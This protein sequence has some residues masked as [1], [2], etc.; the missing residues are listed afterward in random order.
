MDTLLL[1]VNS[2]DLSVVDGSIAVVAGPYALAQ[3]VA[4]ACRLYLGELWYDTTQGMPY[5]QRILGQRPPL[6]FIQAQLVAAA[7]GVPG[8]TQA[9]AVV[10]LN[11]TNRQITG[12]IDLT[13]AQG[14]V[15]VGGVIGGA[16]WYI[17]GATGGAFAS[18]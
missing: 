12:T 17:S 2:W 11:D 3:D 4:S 7:L 14:A 13:S 1:D 15:T 16:Q 9:V 6:G 18:P 10:T 5:S 8:V